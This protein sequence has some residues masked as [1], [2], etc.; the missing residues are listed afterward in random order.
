MPTM[1]ED[2]KIKIIYKW[3]VDGSPMHNALQ[4]ESIH[5]QGPGTQYFNRL[6][7]SKHIAVPHPDFPMAWRSVITF[8]TVATPHDPVE[9]EK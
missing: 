2:T 8:R 6:H 9:K 5:I 4:K 3:G 1:I 7:E